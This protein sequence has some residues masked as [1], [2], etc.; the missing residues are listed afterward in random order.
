VLMVSEMKHFLHAENYSRLGVLWV[1]D[2]GLPLIGSIADVEFI[3]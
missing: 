1:V 2:D 3:G